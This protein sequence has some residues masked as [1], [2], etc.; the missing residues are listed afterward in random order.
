M[1]AVLPSKVRGRVTG[2]P[3]G[4]QE[5]TYAQLRDRI[6]SGRYAPGQ[7]LTIKTIAREMGTSPMPVREAIRRLE[8][9]GWVVYERYQG[10]MVA[11]VNPESGED[12]L[13][14]LALLEGYATALGAPH[15]VAE[16]F[17]TLRALNQEMRDSMA[18]MDAL[19]AFDA[20]RRFHRTIYARCPNGYMTFHVD[21][22]WERWEWL[23]VLPRA[24]FGYIP[25]R[26]L[27][28]IDEHEELM[29]MIIDGSDTAAIERFMRE[30]TMRT[31]EAYK[32]AQASAASP[33]DAA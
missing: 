2:K 25:A 19:R 27:A 24:V 32:R 16:D 21:L 15:L 10:A 29:T 30:H 33:S 26:G 6:L 31:V 9:E 5:H 13:T 11:P 22:A 17:D 1:P 23:N 8:A 3:V 12:A 14:T 28:S 7:K 20:N 4:K 18:Q